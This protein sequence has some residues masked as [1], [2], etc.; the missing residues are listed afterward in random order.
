[1]GGLQSSPRFPLGSAGV[2]WTHGP[3]PGPEGTGHKALG[4]AASGC[5]HHH[6]HEQ[7][8]FMSELLSAALSVDRGLVLP[9][10]DAL[11]YHGPLC[12]GWRRGGGY[13]GA[14][15]RCQAPALM[16]CSFSLLSSGWLIGLSCLF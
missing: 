15:H 16:L 13:F 10:L 8:F 14:P 5:P 11:A 3:L 12:V 6:L 2:A 9:W 1:M 4:V 7:P